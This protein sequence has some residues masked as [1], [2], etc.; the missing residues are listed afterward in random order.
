MDALKL[1]LGAGGLEVLLN[2]FGL[3]DLVLEPSRLHILLAEVFRPEGASVIEREMM[4]ELCRRTGSR[5]VERIGATYEAML[6]EARE[7]YMREARR[8]G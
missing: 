8:Q 1:T 2:Q 5:I 3:K 7:T 6:A 4:S